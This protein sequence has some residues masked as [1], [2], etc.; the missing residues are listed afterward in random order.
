[1]NAMLCVDKEDRTSSDRNASLVAETVM[2][3][4]HLEPEL[5]DNRASS[6]M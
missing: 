4:R 3:A 2:Y 6:V 5:E 1:M